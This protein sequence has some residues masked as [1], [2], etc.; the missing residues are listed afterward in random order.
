M[1]MIFRS[2]MLLAVLAVVVVG[3]AA[4][5]AVIILLTVMG[6][7]HPAE[8]TA[9]FFPSDTQIYLSVNLSPGNDQLRKFR[10]IVQ[11]FREHPD[12][13]RKIDDWLNEADTETGIDL[14][15]DVLPWL[16]PEI[17]IG[18]VDVVGSTIAA[19]TG[20]P[21]LVLAL[22]GATDTE[23]A[24]TFLQDWMRYQER[25]ENLNFE[26]GSYAGLTVYSEDGGDQHYA[27][28]AEYVLLATDRDL[29]EETIDRMEDGDTAGSLHDQSRFQ[30]ARGQLPDPRF[31]M[32]Y[33][34]AKAVW[35]DTRRQLGDELPVE[36]SDQLDNAIPEWLAISESFIDKGIKL[37]VVTA[38]PEDASDEAPV[39]NSLASAR[40]LPGDTLSFASF[41]F[42][43]DLDPLRENL[44]SQSIEDLGPDFYDA[45]YFEFGLDVDPEG[46]LDDV[47][48]AV[49]ASFEEVSGLD[50]ERD[51]LGWMTGEFSLALLPTDF[52]ALS[53]DP[54]AEP[55]EALALVQF[56]PERLDDLTRAVKR[57]VQLLEEQLGLQPEPISYGGG[58]GA[59]FNIQEL[60]GPTVYLP[61]YLIL[62]EHLM[63]A[64]T[65]DALKL[66]AV[67]SERR[68]GSL[69][70]A[71]RYAR[72]V[73][74]LSKATNPLVYVNLGSIIDSVVEAL[75]GDD[76]REYREDAEPFIEPLEAFFI[77]GETRDGV[78]LVTFTLTIE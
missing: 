6:E 2:P 46:T 61:G 78:T 66:A 4:A 26:T 5:A 53:E 39:V 1:G 75:D 49:L 10:D 33:I 27:V 28:T 65:G 51:V 70:E 31:S 24:E 77:G 71:A 22:I 50:F 56:D 73:K 43:P 58:Q 42:E 47:L 3:S 60:V 34:D 52:E 35:L 48:D 37:I 7:A 17:A 29:L 14:K 32:L 15:M 38:M 36:I 21:P 69:A 72:G 64:T 40:L 41:A 8:D 74:D 19:G 20:G 59:T 13:Q 45:L 9:K 23:K 54:A 62:D 63:I 16:G 57:A 12:F 55:I 67:T 68:E 18:L 25:E 44:E 11:R 30:E 76:L